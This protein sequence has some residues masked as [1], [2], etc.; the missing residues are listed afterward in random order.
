MN[1]IRYV[2]L[3]MTLFVTSMVYAASDP[4]P[5]WNDTAAKQKIIQ[6]VEQTTNPDSKQFVPVSDRVATFD[7][8]GTLWAEQPAYFQLYFT[9]A[10]VKA[11]APQHPEWKTEQPFAALL[12][13]DTKKVME[14]GVPGLLKLVMATHSGMTNE[15]FKG[16]VKAWLVESKHP[17]TNKNY[18]DMTYQPMLEL[19]T[20]FQ[21]HD[22]KTYIV[23]AGGVEFMRAWAPA[24]YN[25]PVDQIIGSS[26]E[27]EYKVVNGE[28]QV[29]R[30]PK[31]NVINDGP[32][33]PISIAQVIGQRPIAA[34]GNSDGDREMLEWTMAGSGLRLAGL[35]HHTDAKREWA[36]DKN[37]HIGQLDKALTQAQKNNWLVVDMK[38]DWNTVFRTQK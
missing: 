3:M 1:T 32:A 18:V 21:V 9:F 25:I 7:N 38:N 17:T 28:P 34:F 6:F 29:V 14:S 27:T 36:Y 8:D 24:V 13:G 22:F 4:L 5:S 10:R 15:E 23:S 20:Y 11:L 2:L 12:A 16:L 33:K 30:V 37:S 19:L 35:I 31:V 26:V